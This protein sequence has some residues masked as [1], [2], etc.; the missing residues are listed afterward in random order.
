MLCFRKFPVAKTIM[1]KW[2]EGGVSRFFLERFLSH[3]A[4]KFH[5]ESFIV[6]LNAIS[7]KVRDKREG[8]IHNFPWNMFCLTVR[9][10]SVEEPFCVLEK[11]WYRKNSV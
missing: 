4:D 6:S 1:D 11:F 9:K 8:G 10:Y 2:G 3:G 5:R 7:K